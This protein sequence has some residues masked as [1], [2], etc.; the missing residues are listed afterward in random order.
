MKITVAGF[1]G[2]FASKRPMEVPMGTSK[3]FIRCVCFVIL[4]AAAGTAQAQVGRNPDG[5]TCFG[6]ACEPG[7]TFGDPTPFCFGGNCDP[8]TARPDPYVPYPTPVPY[9]PPY[10]APPY[11]P[12]YSYGPGQ[13]RSNPF[14]APDDDN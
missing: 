3:G 14:S 1:R 9:S 7:A 2:K 8:V 11:Q 6:Q 10:Q 12:N 5:E 13:N 4:F